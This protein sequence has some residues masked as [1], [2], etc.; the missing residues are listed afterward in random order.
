[1]FKKSSLMEVNGYDTDTVGED[2][3]L[4]LKLQNSG[5]NALREE[6]FMNQNLSVIQ[7]RQKH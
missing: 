6:L 4:V 3:E 5:L 7:E 1:M 2:M